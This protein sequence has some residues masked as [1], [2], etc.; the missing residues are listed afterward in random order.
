MLLCTTYYNIYAN[1][2]H[3]IVKPNEMSIIFFF[4]NKRDAL[5]TG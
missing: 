2:L 5:L 1:V 3:L 4:K